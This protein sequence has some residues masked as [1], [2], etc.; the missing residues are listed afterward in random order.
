MG[1]MNAACLTL[2]IPKVHCSV[3]YVY[4]GLRNS[5]FSSVFNKKRIYE[6]IFPLHFTNPLYNLCELLMLI[7]FQ[8]EW[9]MTSCRYLCGGY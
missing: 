1:P 8:S 6:Y 2:G 3:I 9:F 5:H 4:V 7:T